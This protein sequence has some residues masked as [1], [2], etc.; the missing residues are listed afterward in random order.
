MCRLPGP[1]ENP[2]KINLSRMDSSDGWIASSTQLIQFLDHVGGAPG[3]AALLKPETIQ[4]MTT[5]APAYPQG[6]A[7]YARGWMV[8]DNGA[9][10]WWHSGSLPGSSALM[11]RN[12]DGSC[13]AALC[14]ART[15]PHQE[16]D[17]DLYELLLELAQNASR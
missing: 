2:Y 16:M 13:S 17:N 1:I 14:N 4:V 8:G 5:P 10:S 12:P 15:Q 7:R 3:I 6:N 9:G 11:I